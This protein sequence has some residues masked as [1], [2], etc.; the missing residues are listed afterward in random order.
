MAVMRKP[1]SATTRD[2]CDSQSRAS[3]MRA[4]ATM[5][6]PSETDPGR[7]E[8]T[9]APLRSG[10]GGSLLVLGI[11]GAGQ[12]RKGGAQGRGSVDLPETPDRD[13]RRIVAVVVGDHADGVAHAL[14][15][16]PPHRDVVIL[17]ARVADG[18]PDL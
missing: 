15:G 16:L 13:V 2:T 7:G 5:L 10:R 18:V 11:W 1:Q 17:A 12:A 3:R 9:T 8:R 6:S 4:L 14:E